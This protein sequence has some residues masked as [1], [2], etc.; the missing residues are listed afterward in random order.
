MATPLELLLQL[1]E[2]AT[3][4]QANSR[5]PLVD[6]IL[7]LP[8]KKMNFLLASS[9]SQGRFLKPSSSSP[10]LRPGFKVC[11]FSHTARTRSLVTLFCN[12]LQ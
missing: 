1:Q 11:P 4:P 12:P 10:Q 9:S 2:L 8:L 3:R 7:G 5:N 6:T